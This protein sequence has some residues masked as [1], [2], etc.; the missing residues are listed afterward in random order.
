MTNMFLFILGC[1][2]GAIFGY[3]A[4]CAMNLAAKADRD[5][6]QMQRHVDRVMR[7]RRTL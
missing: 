3:A 5:D 7:R 4:A 6:E 2:L 1:W